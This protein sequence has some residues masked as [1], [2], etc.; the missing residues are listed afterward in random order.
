MKPTFPTVP[1]RA[2]VRLHLCATIA[3]ALLAIPT[4]MFWSQSIL[5]LALMSLWA[6]F[7]GHW[8]AYQAARAEARQDETDT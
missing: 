2:L 7:V 3:W 1:P 4:F 8:S 6:N 5:W